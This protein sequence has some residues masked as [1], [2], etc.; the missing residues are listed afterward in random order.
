[1][2]SR[3][4]PATRSEFKVWRAMTTR[5]ADNDAYGHVNNVQFLRLLEDARVVAFSDWFGQDRSLVDEGVQPLRRRSAGDGHR[6]EAAPG[7]PEQVG[8]QELGVD[9]GT[10]HARRAQPFLR[11]TQGVL[12]AYS[13]VPMASRRAC[14]SIS[15][16]D[17]TT[18]SR[19][20]FM[21]AS[22]L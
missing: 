12:H 15:M 21:T 16:A 6:S 1:M 19:S 5:W 17:C 3:K 9:P 14:S 8:C 4:P 11:R 13:S 10:R 18:G 2:V 22:R 20:P 7:H